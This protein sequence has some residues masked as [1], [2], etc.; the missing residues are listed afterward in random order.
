[1]KELFDNEI[2]ADE[3]DKQKDKEILDKGIKKFEEE[4]KKGEEEQ[5]QEKG[6]EEEK[7]LI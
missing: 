6:K 3:K 1:M 4:N 7:P 2:W 5:E